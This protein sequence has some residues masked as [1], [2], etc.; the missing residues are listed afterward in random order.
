MCKSREV[1]QIKTFENRIIVY[2]YFTTKYTGCPPKRGKFDLI[3]ALCQKIESAKT[4]TRYVGAFPYTFDRDLVGST[5]K[6]PL[7]QGVHYRHV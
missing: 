4:I 3:F 6:W 7:L 5:K 1:C 2:F